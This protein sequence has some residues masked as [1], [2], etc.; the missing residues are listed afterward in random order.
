MSV[1]KATLE[2]MMSMDDEA[3]VDT[4]AICDQLKD[5]A[6]SSEAEA[7]EMVITETEDTC[8]MSSPAVNFSYGEKG[9]T[10]MGDSE[11]SEAFDEMAVN[12]FRDGNNAVFELDPSSL[13]EDESAGFEMMD[14]LNFS[15]SFPGDVLEANQGGVVSEDKHTVT[16]DLKSAKAAAE[17][18]EKLV[19]TGA[20]ATGADSLIFIIGGVVLLLAIGGVVTA[21]VLK[22]RKRDDSDG[23]SASEAPEGIVL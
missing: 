16:W 19:A 12:V 20:I 13:L 21:V 11:A 4:T 8:I 23:P 2:T 9:I 6:G 15:I 18:G 3:A 10:Q 7:S 14:G 5:A 1:K 22:N 17:S